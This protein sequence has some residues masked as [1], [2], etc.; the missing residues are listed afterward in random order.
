MLK[1]HNIYWNDLSFELETGRPK[2]SS[3]LRRGTATV[4]VRLRRGHS[5]DVCKLC[6]CDAD[7]AERIVASSPQAQQFLR[8]PPKIRVVRPAPEPPPPPPE[9]QSTADVVL[10]EDMNKRQLVEYAEAEGLDVKKN[11]SKAKI[12]SAVE[13][14]YH[15]DD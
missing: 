2:A 4:P 12:L 9:A 14:Y 13:Q 11:W 1:L 15:D 7:E 3:R 10:F 8:S 5:V 6:G